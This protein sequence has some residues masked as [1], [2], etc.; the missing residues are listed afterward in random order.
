MRAPRTAAE[1]ARY[2]ET[3]AAPAEPVDRYRRGA[4]RDCQGYG[5]DRFPSS[6]RAAGVGEGLLGYQSLPKAGRMA[7]RFECPTCH[8]E[9]ALTA[10]EATLGYQ[11]RSCTGRDA[12][13]GF[14]AVG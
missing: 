5:P 10:R 3:M 9:G 2:R 12:G 6:L 14:E 4:G 11:C 1:L 8:H 7:G 13:Y